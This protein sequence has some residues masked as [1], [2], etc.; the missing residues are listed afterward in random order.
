MTITAVATADCTCCENGTFEKG[1]VL[2]KCKECHH[3]V[4]FHKIRLPSL[5][6]P[7]GRRIA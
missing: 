6:Q 7:W 5:W 3:E 1:E 4:I 2:G